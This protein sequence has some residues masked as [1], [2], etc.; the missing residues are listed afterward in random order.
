MIVDFD[1]VQKRCRLLEEAARGRGYDGSV[2]VDLMIRSSGSFI[3][4]SS[5]DKDINTRDGY[6]RLVPDNDFA[7]AHFFVDGSTV[8]EGFDNVVK[9]LHATP[10]RKQRELNIIAAKCQAALGN[11]LNFSPEIRETVIAAL[12]KTFEEIGLPMITY[13]PAVADDMPF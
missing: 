12:R 3:S 4:I 1:H 9:A 6:H 8:D 10:T 11:D 13:Q 2:S 7:A 5:V